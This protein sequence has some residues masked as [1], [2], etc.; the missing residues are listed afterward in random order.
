MS[1][2]DGST[3]NETPQSLRQGGTAPGTPAVSNTVTHVDML[4]QLAPG[5][6]VAGRYRIILLRGVGGVGVVYRARDEVLRIDVALKLLR[7]D[8]GQEPQWIERF[9]REIL[10]AR[11]VSHRN[12]VRLHDIGESEGLRFL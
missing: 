7:P 2:S 6:L 5:T 10:L 12:V 8:L 11:D 3:A 1:L 9:R 4:G